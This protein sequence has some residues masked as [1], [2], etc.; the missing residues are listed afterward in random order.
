MERDIIDPFKEEYLKA[1]NAHQRRHVAV[2]KILVPLFNYWET[3]GNQTTIE[4]GSEVNSYCTGTGL[5]CV[6]Q[7]IA[8]I[9]FAGYETIGA[10]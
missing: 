1:S 3:I 8:R 4:Q 10:S 7:L 5:I 9:C 2:T 6:T